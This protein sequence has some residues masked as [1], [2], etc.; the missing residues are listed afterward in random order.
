M[1]NEHRHI[2]AHTHTHA[3]I[4]VPTGSRNGELPHNFCSY[5]FILQYYLISSNQQRI[6]PKRFATE[7]SYIDLSNISL[8]EV[9]LLTTS[10]LQCQM[11]FYVPLALI[12]T[13]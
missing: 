7:L 6:C 1:A 12:Q 11:Y 13:N 4:A 9:G 3:D 2:Q 10:Q 5:I 8:F